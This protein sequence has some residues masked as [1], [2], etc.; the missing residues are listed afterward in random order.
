M[1]RFRMRNN[2]R[3]MK[4]NIRLQIML[5]CLSLL[6]IP[7]LLVSA[8]SY[9]SAVKGLDSGG[10]KQLK[11][12]VK[13]TIGLIAM[14]DSQV[15]SGAIDR[16][17]AEEF[18]KVSM[19]GPKDAAGK[20]PINKN[21]D[22]GKNGYPFA[23]DTD[24]IMVA[25]PS[26][27]GTSLIGLKNSHGELAVDSELGLPI[28]EAFLKKAESGGGFVYYDWTLPGTVDE[29]ASK[30]IYLEKDPHWG[31]IVA[32][33]TYMMDFNQSA[34]QIIKVT[35]VTLLIT[36][37]VGIA[38][39]ML[40]T[41]RLTKPI[42]QV[43]KLANEVAL[44]NLQIEPIVC[45]RQDEVGLLAN[46]FNAMVVQLKTL[47]G[48]VGRSVDQVASSS[49]ELMA[50]G[51]QT[52]E[53]S[54]HIAYTIQMV[55]DGAE[56]Q[57]ATAEQSYQVIHGMSASVRQIADSTDQVSHLAK[58]TSDKAIEGSEALSLAVSQM[59]TIEQSFNSLALAVQGL[60]TRSNEI[61]R[62]VQVISDISAQTNLLALNASIEAA[63]AGEHG[64]GFAVVAGEVR[65]LAE[66]TR[67]SSEHIA[68]V[69]MAVGTETE[70]VVLAMNE[71]GNVVSGGI[72][73]VEGAGRMF[74]SIRDEVMQVAQQIDEVSEAATGIAAG[75]EQVMQSIKEVV[76]IAVEG[77]S[78][79]QTVAA[80]A[81]QQTASMEEI[82][83]ASA[84]LANMA[85]HLQK[86]ILRFKV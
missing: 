3:S 23:F 68:K 58:K 31:W 47:V 4:P 46:S 19:L 45:K 11:N 24:S 51:E 35:V 17:A 48:E 39:A 26:T 21:I 7:S 86:E 16:A 33:G 77:A 43:S 37:V 65:K 78:G 29:M 8:L 22:L 25:H 76:D 64:K 61:V 5:L 74:G 69:V 70:R 56:R 62:M 1:K 79:T 67:E 40:F 10:Q 34:N 2:F 84:M 72:D 53:A 49:E 42:K 71:A 12:S 14:L 75:T 30:V 57:S 13:S 15:K 36:I 66:Q 50:S 41:R 52:S 28:T 6:L 83:A 63:R 32:S 38:A 80:A 20:R 9:E 27:E 55:A 44:G 59:E 60:G 85:E 18:V 54:E 81:Q 82:A 73:A